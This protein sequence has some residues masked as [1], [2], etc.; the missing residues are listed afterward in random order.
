[1]YIKNVSNDTLYLDKKDGGAFKVP[2]RSVRQADPREL[3]EYQLQ[4]H[5]SK[6]DILMFE[7]MEAAAPEPPAAAAEEGRQPRRGGR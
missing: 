4:Y 5:Q 2:A 3:I 6:G 7:R 1:M